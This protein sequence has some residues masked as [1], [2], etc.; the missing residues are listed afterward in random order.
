MTGKRKAALAAAAALAVVGA[1]VAG[2]VVWRRDRMP[3]GFLTGLHPVDGARAVVTMRAN[4]SEG[5]S[6]AW[7]ALV[8]AE[9]GLRWRREL[10]ALPI[11]APYDG[12]SVGGGVVT[13]RTESG[14]AAYALADGSLR[15]RA[16]APRAD[17]AAMLADERQLVELTSEG[18]ELV[19]TA[20][21]RASGARQ[22]R[23]ETRLSGP[24]ASRAALTPGHIVFE[25]VH[26]LM[27]FD[28]STGAPA[29]ALNVRGPGC[30][31]GG[32]LL[33]VADDGERHPLVAVDLADPTRRRMIVSNWVPPGPA[34][35]FKVESCGT[36]G[37]RLV[38]S[39]GRARDGLQL[40]LVDPA[41]GAIDASI[42]LGPVRLG[43]SLPQWEIVQRY[44]GGDPLGGALPRF[45]PVLIDRSADGDSTR[46]VVVD[47]DE[48]RVARE[49][50]MA[51]DL[52]HYSLQRDGGR[53][54]LSGGTLGRGESLAV[55]DGAT[56]A[57]TAALALPLSGDEVLPYHFRDGRVWI[58]ASD[59]RRLDRAPWAVL[60]AATLAPAAPSAVKLTDGMAATLELTGL[61]RRPE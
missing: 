58:F 50:T 17:V 57:I 52:I 48:R 24:D 14:I 34:A 3:E 56:G 20:Y 28:R 44:A 36:R 42:D 39:V 16:D 35:Y 2:W 23:K 37:E 13:V 21:A 61:P 38:I 4:T 11:I 18:G 12:L 8:D 54:V 60:D 46:L 33:V 40:V 51:H 43:G 10:P 25:P 31:V 30:V 55:I 15:W 6:R 27:M 29:L 49:G 59:W 47:L 7:V 32:E 45:V 9:K 26:R 53:F 41:S 22:W 19:M 1:A 5:P